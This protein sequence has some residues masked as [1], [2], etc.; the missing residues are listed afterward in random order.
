MLGIDLCGFSIGLEYVYLCKTIRNSN[1]VALT[2]RNNLLKKTSLKTAGLVANKLFN[3]KL[4]INKGKKK[5]KNIVQIVKKELSKNFNIKIQYLECRN[6]INLSTN[7]NNK[8]FK[9][10]VAYYLNNV[11]LIDNF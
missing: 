6:L 8:P 1:K 2:S 5:H 10:F 9:V 3:L 4:A 7:I 11:R